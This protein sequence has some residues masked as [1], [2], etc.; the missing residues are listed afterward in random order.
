MELQANLAD[1]V[2]SPG[3]A[4]FMP[5]RAFRNQVRQD[6]EPLRFVDGELLERFL[7]CSPEVQ[8]HAVK[9]LGMRVE[10]MRDLVE[11]LRRLH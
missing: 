5:F 2:V 1:C 8:E 6:E 10:E 7:D 9:G 11:G 4:P 3:N